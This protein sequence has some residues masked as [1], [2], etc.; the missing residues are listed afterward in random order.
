MSSN[1]GKEENVRKYLEFIEEN[2]T[3]QKWLVPFWTS[4]IRKISFTNQ[5]NL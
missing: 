1:L 5:T 2:K 3:K 4:K